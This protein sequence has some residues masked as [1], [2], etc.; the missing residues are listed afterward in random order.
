MRTTMKQ[1][2]SHSRNQTD[3]ACTLS[4][5]IIKKNADDLA[6]YAK[7][8]Q[9]YGFV[10]IVEPEVLIDGTHSIDKCYI[11]TENVLSKVFDS[12]NNENV[13]IEFKINSKIL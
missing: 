6:K 9:Q 7:I 11:V 13:I 4:Q 1:R 8:C 10:P 3:S 5:I 2:A 12:L